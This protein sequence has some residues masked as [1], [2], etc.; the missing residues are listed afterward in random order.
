MQTLI[1]RR[2]AGRLLAV[3]LSAYAGRRDVVVLALPR[4]GVPVAY[5]IA[6]ALRVPL[7]VIVVRKLGAPGYPELAMGAIAGN[8]VCILN[9]GVLDGLHVTRAEFDRVLEEERLELTRRERAYRGTHPPVPLA[10]RTVILVDDGL[11]TGSTMSA[12]VTAATQQHAAA[13]VVAVPVSSREAADALE[14]EGHAVFTVMMPEPFHGVGRWYEDFDPTSDDE[15]VSLLAAA[16]LGERAPELVA[17]G[18]NR[19]T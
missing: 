8:D 2:Q 10:G 13:V 17:G 18:G 16:W 15:V 4:G 5:E 6:R 9:R 11:A 19:T 3:R 7:D 14:A 12:A 1:N